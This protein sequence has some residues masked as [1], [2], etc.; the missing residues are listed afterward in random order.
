M[1]ERIVKTED[2]KNDEFAK[3]LIDE[4]KS[5]EETKADFKIKEND[6]CE[7]IVNKEYDKEFTSIHINKNNN[8]IAV[9]KK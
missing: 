9:I 1:V 8:K 3:N 4:M 5:I 2:L 6:I 7:I